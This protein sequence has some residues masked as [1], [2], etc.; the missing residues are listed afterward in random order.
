MS[1][2]IKAKDMT[3]FDGPV[4]TGD[5]HGKRAADKRKVGDIQPDESVGK[6]GTKGAELPSTTTVGEEIEALFDGVEG[7]SEDFVSRASTIVEGAISEKIALVREDLETEYNQRLDEAYETL[8]EDLETKL[9]EYLGLF[10]GEYLKEN[11]VAIESGFRTEIA[12]QVISNIVSIVESA[13]VNLPEDKIDLADA[14]VAENEDLENKYNKTLKENIELKKE[15]RTYAIN[16]AFVAHTAD[17]SDGAK[18][19]L[20]RLTE[21][22]EFNDVDQFV[23]KLE[24]LKESFTTKPEGASKQ[25]LTEASETT[26]AEKKLDPRMSHYVAAARGSYFGSR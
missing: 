12:E 11:Q 21:N 18:D 7:L 15:I 22:M 3:E 2:K 16:E 8:A 25:N 9:D 20:R 24:V 1:E 14:L 6:S 17:L 10:I 4:D 23:E 13:G 19:K 26:V 5:A